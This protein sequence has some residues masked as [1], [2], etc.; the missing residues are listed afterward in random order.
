MVLFSFGR[1]KDTW[2]DR[3]ERTMRFFD[4][5]LIA[6]AIG[7]VSLKWAFFSSSVGEAVPPSL[8]KYCFPF[9]FNLSAKK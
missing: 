1:E 7:C 3:E 5:L 2:N 9:E 8:T 6:S 4:V